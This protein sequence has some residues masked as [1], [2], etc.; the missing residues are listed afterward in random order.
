[1][2]NSHG[3]LVIPGLITGTFGNPKFEPDMQQFSLM[4]LKGIVPTSDNPFGVL[5]TLFGQGNQ[6][7]TKPHAQNP[8]QGVEKFLGKILGRK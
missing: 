2:E 5:G 4:K 7:E 8:S 6:D 3:E 1:M